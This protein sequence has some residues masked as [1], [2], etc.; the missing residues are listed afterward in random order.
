MRGVPPLSLLLIACALL[1]GLPG[2]VE[3]H[4]H[5]TPPPVSLDFT[6]LE[7]TIEAQLL[8]E[9]ALAE[10]WL[11]EAW[12]QPEDPS[13]PEAVAALTKALLSRFKFTIDDGTVELAGSSVIT[14]ASFDM[15]GEA[16]G[17][18]T[19]KLLLEAPVAAPAQRMQLVWTNFSGILWE[20]KVEF[21]VMVEADRVSDSALL[22]PEEPV[23]NWRRRPPDFDWSKPIASVDAPPPPRWSVPVGSLALGALG[24]LALLGMAFRLVPVRA[25]ALGA[26][27]CLA[28]GGA[29]V[30]VRA[31]RIET[32]PLWGQQ[33]VLPSTAQAEKI[34]AT[35]HENIYRSF[36][37]PG[38]EETER[39]REE[40][41]Y[42]EL[43]TSVTPDLI[44]PLFVEI[45][46]SLVLREE[47][48][49]VCH[50]EKVEKVAGTVTFPGEAWAHHF[51]VDWH[52]RVLGSITHWGH[53]HRRMNVYRA[54]YLVKHDGGSWRIA[55]IKVQ[56]H[57]RIDED[58]EGEL[59]REVILMEPGEGSLP[60][61]DEV[62]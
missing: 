17:S 31:L 34:F 9:V 51:H 5:A 35:L 3:A 36:A 40:R 44:D 25:G 13:D 53:T 39:E 38:Q 15:A 54:R 48:G 45:L 16:Q 58:A 20:D 7:N 30:P 60:P 1:A 12:Y 11:G 10:H 57:R 47:N 42:R 32:E 50:V 6:M 23:F 49:V 29:L 2:Q 22:S 46:E 8:I 55:S 43:A 28:V 61:P 62:K 4:P 19:L 18:E 33:S 24:V 21:P 14:L 52:W 27:A 37:D 41:I 26:V 59:T 56:E